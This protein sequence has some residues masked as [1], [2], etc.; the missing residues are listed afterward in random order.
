MGLFEQAKYQ[1]SAC[2]GI[3]SMVNLKNGVPR[4]QSHCARLE[5]LTPCSEH[6]KL[7]SFKPN[8][9]GQL[10]VSLERRK[11]SG[12]QNASQIGTK[13]SAD[14]MAINLKRKL[15]GKLVGKT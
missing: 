3:E 11:S 1:W 5:V 9:F 8:S 6:F 10:F 4:M 2:N 15:F 13:V 7:E 12:V 14:E